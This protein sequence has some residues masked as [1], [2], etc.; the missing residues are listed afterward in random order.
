MT[1]RFR[2]L[3]LF[4]GFF[5][6]LA[7][8]GDAGGM[9]KLPDLG[10]GS[11]AVISPAQERKLGEDFM[12]RAR[13]Q[14]AFLDDPEINEYIQTLGQRLVAASEGAG[15]DFRFF[16]VRDPTIN[17]FAVPGGFIGV[18]TGLIL[19]ARNEAELAAVL[20]HEI[21]HI[22]QRHIPRL[23]VESQRTTL[24][25]MAAILASILLASSGHQ[26]AE[27]GIALSTAAVAQ[28]EINFT[29]AFEEEAD[30]L[31]MQ[32]LA[33]AGFDPR[34]MPDF[35]ERLQSL[36]RY[37]ETNL[38]EFLRTH[39]VT[40]NRI[41]DARNRAERLPPPRSPRPG[42]EDSPFYHIQAKLRALA[43]GDP[44]EIARGFKVNLA[45]HRYSQR[46]A[47]RYGYAMAL[48]RTRA[49]DD[50]RAECR[51]LL[52]LSPKNLS[53]RLLLA[54]IERQ[55][56]RQPQAL[57]EYA[58]ALALAPD[59]LAVQ[60]RYANALLEAGR[61]PDAIELLR[62]AVRQRPD[63]PGL[64]KLLAQAAGEAGRPFEAHQAMAEYYYFSGNL[65]AALEQLRIASRYAGDDFYRQSSVEARIEAIKTEIALFQE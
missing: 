40:V 38:P 23:I 15:R 46:E 43:P 12:R 7:G 29:R 16:V 3:L 2:F 22:T 20:A 55:S 26:G 45:Q 65:P 57:A 5:W 13:R 44:Q 48:L 25:A 32:I 56:G 27:A 62:K 24:P 10:D 21:A 18:H 53:Y 35:F 14:L 64:Y 63:E 59:N 52:S 28:R 58:R 54:E 19:A 30:R 9:L 6:P 42:G 17:A 47:E 60:Q 1:R 39:P 51:A 37:N 36:N 49:F 34:A 50:A 11:A 4:A 41:A 31:G 33:Q 8:A 61:A